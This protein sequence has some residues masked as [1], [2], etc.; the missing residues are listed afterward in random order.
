MG[1]VTE[2][3]SPVAD[4]ANKDFT[5]SF[6]P[7]AGSEMVFFPVTP[8]ER[9]AAKPQGMQYAR[10]STAITFG[11]APLAGRTPWTRYFVDS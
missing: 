9:V 1:W 10:D 3:V 8:L 11:D 5:I 6:V 7:F 4:G 2:R